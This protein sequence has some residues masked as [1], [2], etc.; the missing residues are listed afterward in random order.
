MST[1]THISALVDRI[2][3]SGLF[4]E[5]WY[6][7]TYPDVAQSG[8]GAIEH[9][10]RF[11]AWLG[12]EPS[13]DFDTRQYM[14]ENPDVDGKTIIPFVHSV[15]RDDPPDAP[16]VPAEEFHLVT[17][18]PE[19]YARLPLDEP[20]Y[21]LQNPDVAASGLEPT[22]HFETSGYTALR[23]PRP[24]FDVWWYTQNYLLGTDA[25]DANAL[26]HYNRI[27]AEQ[28]HSTRPPVPVCFNPAASKP[29]AK[30]PR[31]I[32]LFAAYDAD[33]I[34]D[35][36][37]LEYLRDLSK[38]ADIYYLADCLMDEDE[39]R[40]LD[41]LVKGAWAQRHGMYDFGSYSVLARDL[42]GW[43]VI[44]SY[45]ELIL[46]NDSCYLVHPLAQT[47]ETMA[48]RPCAWWGLQATKGLIST[49]HQN[50][51]PE[52]APV[53][54][55]DIKAH[56]LTRFEH[57]PVYDFH[58]GSY[59]MAF[60]RDVIR[61]EG[62]RRV[63]N[64][65]AEESN[66]LNIIRKYEIGITRFLIGKGYEFDTLVGSV[67][68]RHPIFT[69]RAFD[70]IDEGFPLLKRYFLTENHY[71]IKGL[72]QWAPRVQAANPKANIVA[73]QKNLNR[74]GHALKLY[75][76]FHIG[77][78]PILSRPPRSRETMR[79]QDLL[80]PKYDHWW[81]FPVCVHS[82]QF[83]DNTRAVFDHVKHDPS[84]KKIILTRGK[85][86]ETDGVNVIIVPLHS[87]EGQSYLLRSRQVFL[88]HGVEA[89]IE[90][91]LSDDLHNFHNLW[92]GIPLK[93]IGYTS[94]DQAASIDKLV[95]E[96]KRLTSV[97][98]SSD[99]DRLAMTAAYWPLTFHDIWVTGLPRHDTIMKPESDLPE[100]MRTRAE[101]LKDRLKGRR[102]MLFAP[103]FRADQENGYYSFSDTEVQQLAA[104]LKRN[105]MAMGIREHMADKTRLYSSQLRGECF[106]D[107]SERH[108]PDVELLYRHADMLL[109]DY[110]SCFIDFML[111]GRPMASFAFD[112]YS[113]ANT[114]RGMFYDQE[115]V[116]PG[117][118]CTDFASLMDGLETLLD[119]PTPAERQAYEWKV[120][121]FHKF[122][123]DRNSERV[124]ARVKEGYEGSEL[125]WEMPEAKDPT[126]PRAITFVC[127]QVNNI[128]NRYRIYNLV[129]HLRAVGWTC[130]IVLD[131]ALTPED[132]QHADAMVICR[133]P[134]SETLRDHCETFHEHGGKIIFDLDDLVHDINAFSGS[135]YFRKRPEFASDFT[136]LSIRTCQMIE[137]ADLVT[138]TTPALAQSIAKMGKPVEVV[139]NT[140][141]TALLDIYGQAETPRSKDDT[142]RICYLSGTATHSEDFAQCQGAA[143]AVLKRHPQAELH[144]VG[145]L[146]VDDDTGVKGDGV[147]I[148]HDVM[149]YEAMQGFLA[150]MDI[151]LA[152]LA[153]GYFNDCKSEL[154][155]F[156]AALHLVPTVASPTR[157]Y[158]DVIEHDKTGLLAKTPK[159]WEAALSRLIEEPDLRQRIGRAA[160]EQIVPQFSSE[161]SALLLAGAINVLLS[162]TVLPQA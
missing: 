5:D 61:D 14:R 89:N 121:F 15:T 148:H 144:I 161:K 49:M 21:L 18:D 162:D 140:M 77:Q 20:F 30:T 42:V 38:H 64:T 130:R 50:L 17:V 98:A 135:E 70:L 16:E 84:I 31:R 3:L 123:D 62:F 145:K 22:W 87:Y 12:R 127:S 109:T 83:S 103:T 100:D 119:D 27:G 78:D 45:D 1:H 86:I 56:H 96:N 35:E 10:L 131:H 65:V 113:Y 9:F 129:E 63:L 40:K 142:V 88:R 95:A 29:L 133:L 158:S 71:K 2:R 59:F 115:M 60:R 80:V 120:D 141:S 146:S 91:A 137:T 134:M 111:T 159:D 67:S 132:L 54:I 11:G 136:V 74:V 125:L 4:D 126:A 46:A 154:K 69:E 92:H 93:R 128:T 32:C 116:F 90:Y 122:R 48:T 53:S 85:H 81:A 51:I 26:K 99:V 52:G 155:I 34:V 25:A 97:I 72:S 76:N 105:N 152:P 75:E 112:Q 118:V 114:Q 110:S 13:P 55:E 39:L 151:N 102:F 157:S 28:G 101:H 68:K 153:P 117:P 156:E 37:V 108:Y 36:A 149:P 33:G 24:D 138:V 66:K 147:V 150:G 106:F 94:L 79:E 104:W 143:Q 58:V 47:F 57:D 139:P 124:V 41:G 8:L 82:H 107:A 7:H 44:D 43:D 160:F 23:N 73:M 6:L 19:D